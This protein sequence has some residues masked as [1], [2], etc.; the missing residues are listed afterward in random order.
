MHSEIL[1]VVQP[2][3]GGGHRSGRCNI[4]G[5][6]SGGPTRFG[7]FS[8]AAADGAGGRRQCC[9]RFM[10]RAA[11]WK[12]SRCCTKTANISTRAIA[13]RPCAGSARTL[14]EC[15]RV[16]LNFLQR[17]IRSGHAGA[18]IRAARGRARSARCSIRARPRRDCGVSKR[19]RQSAGGVTNHRMGLF[20]AILIK[21]NH[22]AAAGGVQPRDREFARGAGLPIEIEVR[23]LDELNE[24]LAMRRDASAAG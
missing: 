9:R 11:G 1:D 22:I 21:N 23:A 17:L 12:S 3:A 20:D 4:A 8:G 15:E 16:A 2:R 19:Q 13:S 6:R 7:I 24:A 5:V 10:R 18:R 14:L